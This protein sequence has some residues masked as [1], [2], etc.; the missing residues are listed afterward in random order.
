MKKYEI[1]EHTADLKIKAYGKTK[2]ELFLNMLKGMQDF[3]KA[4]IKKASQIKERKIKI[5]SSNLE[6]LLVDFLNEVNFLNETKKEVYFGGE[7]KIKDDKILEGKLFG[8]E[9][10]HFEEDIKAV[11]YHDLKIKKE[12]KIWKGVVLFDI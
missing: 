6:M 2:E 10:S 4:K 1:L 12:N 8:K 5:K 9:V 3:L 7:I 11:T